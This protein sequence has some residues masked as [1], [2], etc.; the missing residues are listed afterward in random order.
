MSAFKPQAKLA[1]LYDLSINTVRNRTKEMRE[2]Q[3]KRYKTPVVIEDGKII[4][5]DENAFL[6]WLNV[7]R[8]VS[9]HICVDPYDP[10]AWSVTEKV[11]Q[12]A[13]N[14]DEIVK[15]VLLEL[16]SVIRKETR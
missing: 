16:S 8:L 15:A 10:K 12:P 2:Q 5:V 7:R 4:L 9:K 1:E 14:T 11:I 3:G 6:D 13:P